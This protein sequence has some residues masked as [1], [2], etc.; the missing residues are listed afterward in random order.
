MC[1]G[2]SCH[3]WASTQESL[4]SGVCEV[5]SAPL[6]FHYL[7]HGIYT[8]FFI[9]SPG[10][11]VIFNIESGQNVNR[12]VTTLGNIS[13]DAALLR[14]IDANITSF[15][16]MWW[17]FSMAVPGEANI[18]SLALGTRRSNTDT[19]AALWRRTGVNITSFIYIMRLLS[20]SLRYIKQTSRTCDF[21]NT[22]LPGRKDGIIGAASTSV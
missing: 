5:W 13:H 9:A 2:K 4:S 20:K 14:C 11:H 22:T 3:I 12:P 1:N 6:L 19:D 17:N 7:K 21:Y 10:L 8:F 18:I 15:D 16:N